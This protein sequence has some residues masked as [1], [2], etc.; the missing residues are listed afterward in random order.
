MN[1]E[2]RT[3]RET[4]LIPTEGNEA[5]EGLLLKTS[6]TRLLFV[7]FANFCWK[8]GGL[9]PCRSFGQSQS[10]QLA[11]GTA[12]RQPLTDAHNNTSRHAIL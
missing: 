12:G 2:G 6:A 10:S 3:A 1:L 9:A 8:L 5:N 7:A 11:C 4:L